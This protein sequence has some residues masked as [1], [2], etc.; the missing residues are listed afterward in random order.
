MIPRLDL[1]LAQTH[2]GSRDERQD[3]TEYKCLLLI[4]IPFQSF[5]P[6]VRRL[7]VA[8]EMKSF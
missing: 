4:N 6:P 2:V 5:F 3:M 7:S 1:G 8:D